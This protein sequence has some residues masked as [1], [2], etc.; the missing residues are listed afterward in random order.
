MKQLMCVLSVFTMTSLVSADL[1]Q[2][3]GSLGYMNVYENMAELQVVFWCFRLGGSM[4][5]KR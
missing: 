5:F 2:F 4:T 3:G 1:A